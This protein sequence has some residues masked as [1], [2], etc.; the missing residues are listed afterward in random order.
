MPDPVTDLLR[1]AQTTN[2]VRASAWDAFQQSADAN[3]LATRIKDLPLPN[4]VKAQLWDAKHGVSAAPDFKTTNATDTSGAPV[5][6]PNTAGTFA[7][8]L[9]RQINPLPLGQMIP[10]PKAVGGAG[11]DAPLQAVKNI[12]AAQGAVFDQAKASFDKGDYVTAGRH[13]VN[14]LLPLIGPVLDQSSNEFQKGQYA[15]GAGD[16]VGLALSMFA[17]KPL[18]EAASKLK[19]PAVLPQ[20][21][22]PVERAAV[23]FGQDRGVPI[24]A[25]TATGNRFVRGTQAL[26]ENSPLGAGVAGR[27]KAGQAAGLARVGGEIANDVYPQA[28][29]PEQAG[30][31]VRG[32]VSTLISD[33]H[34]QATAAY[35]R[36]RQIEANPKYAERAPTAPAGSTAAQVI[37]GKMAAGLPDGNTPTNAQLG[38]LHRILAE[39]T[40][41]P[42]SKRNFN[43]GGRGTGGTLEVSGGAAGAPVYTD[44]LSAS[45]PDGTPFV[46]SD[47]TRGEVVKAI[48]KMLETGDVTNAAQAAMDVARARLAG[49][50]SVTR[51]ILPLSA[52]EVAH[53][54]GKLENVPLPVN[55]TEA[56]ALL[57][58]VYDRIMRQLPV[59]QQRASPGLKAIENILDGPNVA[60]VSVVDA[61]LSVI[62]SLARGADLP[63]LKNVSQGIA[64]AA[65]TRLDKAVRQAVAKAGPEAT[66]ALEEGRAATTAKYGAA[67]VLDQIRQEPVQA[68]GQA[69]YAKD[70]GIQH[71]RQVAELAPAEIPKIG[72]A[73]LDDL[74]STA[75]AGGGFDRA[76]G[77]SAKW[78]ALGPETKQ[79]LFGEQVDSL[80]KFFLL[81]KKIGENPNP[82]GSGITWSQGAQLGL[83]FTS[84]MTG[85]PVVLGTG[86][87]STILHSPTAAK[88]L[89]QGLSIAVGSGKVTT[90]GQ[91]LM[92]FTAMTKAAREAGVS[93]V[94][95]PAVDQGPSTATG[96]K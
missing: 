81:A 31:G 13:F 23:Q 95:A 36:L 37:R 84:P 35:D 87:L 40:S 77:L 83:M 48:R 62:K 90:A 57:K 67:A 52:G 46:G 25:A 50:S 15:A 91:W 27:A 56:K 6:D 39:L 47:M 88:L 22:N 34:G 14:F 75:T 69:V 55:L 10:F 19:L 9:G 63:E 21:P 53:P 41:V 8:H 5:I 79:L 78:Q 73:Y 64:A 54:L 76:Q 82:S 49:S 85:V 71:L 32:A 61:D 45:R 93:L 17:G 18:M 60:P 80:D 3:E 16:A 2:D 33:L 11:L 92:G 94:P 30:A 26:A 51:P 96:R 42:F 38:E 24:D 20:N 74:L 1:A 7:S 4:E 68:Y 65:V 89:T 66:A 70:A 58:P 86:A 44:I 59:A 43:E 28:V 72:R 12:G 29:S